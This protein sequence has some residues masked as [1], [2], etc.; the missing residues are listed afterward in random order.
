MKPLAT[1]IFLAI[2]FIDLL[3]SIGPIASSDGREPP[4]GVRRML[5]TLESKKRGVT[6]GSI[7]R[8]NR[9]A[10]IVGC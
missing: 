9:C 7:E 1:S 10:S 4:A 8:S 6:E 3:G 2:L 5:E